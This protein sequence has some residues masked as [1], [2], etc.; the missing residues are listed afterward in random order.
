[1][2]TKPLFLLELL[3]KK[4]KVLLICIKNFQLHLIKFFFRKDCRHFTKFNSFIVCIRIVQKEKFK[5]SPQQEYENWLE[6]NDFKL[7]SEKKKSDGI[8]R[9]EKRLVGNFRQFSSWSEYLNVWPAHIILPE[10]L[11]Y[12]IEF[13][14]RLGDFHTKKPKNVDFWSL[15]TF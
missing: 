4:I 14:L 11:D 15:E 3:P 8:H 6:K 7:F 12:A 5:N 9:S 2:A 1:M 13:I 10:K